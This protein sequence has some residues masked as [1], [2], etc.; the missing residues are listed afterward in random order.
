[1]RAQSTFFFTAIWFFEPV[2]MFRTPSF[3]WL[4]YM[5][6]WGFHPSRN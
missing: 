2:T 6:L 3:N 1:L 4:L 5:I